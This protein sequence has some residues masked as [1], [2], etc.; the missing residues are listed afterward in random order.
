MN[1]C[2]DNSSIKI[3]AQGPISDDL[4]QYAQRLSELAVNL[5]NS[6]IL[7]ARRMLQGIFDGIDRVAGLESVAVI[8]YGRCCRVCGITDRTAFG[9]A[10]WISDDLCSRCAD[11]GNPQ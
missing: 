1:T 8:D 4:Q 9:R 2:V 3:P 7:E 6:D 11:L 5:P 10:W